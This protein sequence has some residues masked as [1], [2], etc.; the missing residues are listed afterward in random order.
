MR[1]NVKLSCG[2]VRFLMAQGKIRALFRHPSCSVTRGEAHSPSL[3]LLYKTHLRGDP[4]SDIRHN[5]ERGF[6]N[7]V[8]VWLTNGSK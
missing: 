6:G 5:T 7:M 8:P 2:M 3:V 4:G 1:S